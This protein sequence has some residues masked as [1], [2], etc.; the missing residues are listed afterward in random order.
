M[1]GRGQNEIGGMQL[2]ELP[3]AAPQGVFVPRVAPKLAERL[4]RCRMLKNLPASLQ[5]PQITGIHP[6]VARRAARGA[7]I[8]DR[9]AF[10][11]ECFLGE[12]ERALFL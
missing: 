8:F 2:G 9:A 12:V 11:I 7:R 4:Q 3:Q 1:D 10:R 5:A 6:T